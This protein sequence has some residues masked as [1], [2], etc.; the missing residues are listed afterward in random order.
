MNGFHRRAA[1]YAAQL[2]QAEALLPQ[3][4]EAQRKADSEGG[5]VERWNAAERIRKHKATMERLANELDSNRR[6]AA[7]MD[8]ARK[9]YA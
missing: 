9:R 4:E 3:L 6:I 1:D 7:I 5:A 2:E 8:D